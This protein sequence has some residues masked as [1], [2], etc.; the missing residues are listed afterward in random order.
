MSVAQKVKLFLLH[1]QVIDGTAVRLRKVEANY[2]QQ[3]I[4]IFYIKLENF[5]D[6]DPCKLPVSEGIGNGFLNRYYYDK[7][8]HRCREFIY[9]G[10][11]GNANNFLSQE[12]CEVVCPGKNLL[13]SLFDAFLKLVS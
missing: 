13:I 2:I 12:D 7:D 1:L 8:T 11:K 10:S 6:G 9:H 4:I 3:M 5:K